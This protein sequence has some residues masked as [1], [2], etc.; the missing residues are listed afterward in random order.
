M[1]SRII[2]TFSVSVPAFA[3]LSV[4]SRSYRIHALASKPLLSYDR[5]PK[6]M[7]HDVR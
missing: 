5:T 6:L 3:A 1:T 4:S 2:G 7:C